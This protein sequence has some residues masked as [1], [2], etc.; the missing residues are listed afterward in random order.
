M[1]SKGRKKGTMRFTVYPPNGAKQ[2]LLAGD[3]NQWKSQAMR[4]Q[5]NGAFVATVAMKRGC[6]EYKYIV[7]G[8]W[9]SDGENP[10]AAVNCYGT[11]NSVVTVD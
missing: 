5:K 2:V 7:D 8:Q 3:F 10:D 9:M 1:V 4:K 6:Y 11:I